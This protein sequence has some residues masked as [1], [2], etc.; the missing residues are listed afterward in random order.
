[1]PHDPVIAVIQ[2]QQNT[3]DR[4]MTVIETMLGQLFQ[5]TEKIACPPI[6]IPAKPE[7][8]YGAA[9]EIPHTPDRDPADL[10]WPS[11]EAMLSGNNVDGW[12]DNG[13]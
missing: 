2:A 11:V 6:V 1:M 10:D 13:G 7:D 3:I 9:E 4:Q 8:I 12:E 5:L